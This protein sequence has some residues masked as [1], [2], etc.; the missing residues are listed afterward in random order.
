M[1][2]IRRLDQVGRNN[3]CLRGRGKKFNKCCGGLA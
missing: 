1:R 2:D 3:P